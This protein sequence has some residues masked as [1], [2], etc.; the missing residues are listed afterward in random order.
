MQTSFIENS[1]EASC[2]YS[3][4][5]YQFFEFCFFFFFGG[6]GDAP[7]KK[8]VGYLKSHNKE[9]SGN[10]ILSSVWCSFPKFHEN[11]VYLAP[12]PT[13]GFR[14]RCSASSNAG[15]YHFYFLWQAVLVCGYAAFLET[16]SH[17]DHSSLDHFFP[18]TRVISEGQMSKWKDINKLT[19]D[20]PTP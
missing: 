12:C 9:N 16:I 19:S 11:I 4:Y 3:S 7:L 15:L 6:G 10:N 14:V 20:I 13:V 8:T 18:R 2:V 5:S 17:T 1:L